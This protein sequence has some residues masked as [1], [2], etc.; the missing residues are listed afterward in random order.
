MIL[1]DL[2]VREPA[3]RC[4][5]Y[6]R[7]VDLIGVGAQ[8]RRP[9]TVYIDVY[10]R[11]VDGLV[12]L[13]IPHIRDLLQ[14]GDH[15]VRILLVELFVLSAEA[16]LDGRRRPLAQDLIREL[17]RFERDLYVGHIQRHMRPEILFKV[18][19]SDLEVLF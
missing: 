17:Y 5:R 15:A 4:C 3:G 7:T 13:H 1:P 19:H 16:D 18:V 9:Y 12:E 14:F 6:Q 8:L 11:I 2:F 10:G